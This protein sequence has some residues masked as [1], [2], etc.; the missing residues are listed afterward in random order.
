M[1]ACIFLQDYYQDRDDRLTNL[2]TLNGRW[3]H[4]NN[5]SD[6]FSKLNSKCNFPEPI[7]IYI[8]GQAVPFILVSNYPLSTIRY[9]VHFFIIFFLCWES[10]IR[11]FHLIRESSMISWMKE[12]FSS[13]QCD[14]E[15]FRRFGVIIN[16]FIF[17]AVHFF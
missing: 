7:Y 10:S 15:V 12:F 8:F 2:D 17:E 6:N 1:Y 14:L 9:A 16:C 5:E 3:Y 13:S 4:M 11:L